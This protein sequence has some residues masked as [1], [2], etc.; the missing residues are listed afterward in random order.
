MAEGL[1]FIFIINDLLDCMIITFYL[2]LRFITN[3]YYIL[4]LRL[5][6]DCFFLDRLRSRHR[7]LPAGFLGL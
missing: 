2:L 1:A 3:Y 4:L 7:S 5:D 6:D